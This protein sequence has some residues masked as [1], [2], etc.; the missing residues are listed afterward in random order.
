MTNRSGVTVETTKNANGKYVETK[1]SN[2]QAND[3]KT[4]LMAVGHKRNIYILRMVQLQQ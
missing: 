3:E 4:I 1:N 2:T